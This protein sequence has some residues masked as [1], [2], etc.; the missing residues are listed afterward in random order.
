M[1][2]PL[3]LQ[4]ASPSPPVKKAV[5]PGPILTPSHHDRVA[6]I[7]GVINDSNAVSSQSKKWTNAVT[8]AKQL[9]E[10]RD[11]QDMEIAMDKCFILWPHS[12][13]VPNGLKHA[14]TSRLG[15]PLSCLRTAKQGMERLGAWFGHADPD[16][17]CDNPA[18]QEWIKGKWSF[19]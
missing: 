16:A 6:H 7:V 19:M 15:W 8:A 18:F 12:S 4:R 10:H 17:D 14:V 5:K 11:L 9:I 3:H 1:L 13:P 2:R